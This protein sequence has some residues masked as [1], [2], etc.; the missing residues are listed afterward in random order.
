MK[1]S[2]GRQRIGDCVY[3]ALLRAV[4]VGGT[5]KLAR[6]D[7]KAMCLEAGFADVETYIASGNVVFQA[8]M[9]AVEVKAALA[10]RLREADGKSVGVRDRPA[11]EM[12]ARLETIPFKKDPA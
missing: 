8:K 11:D 5:G 7:L 3:V 9:S 1:G 6:A 2:R 4:N 10:E 12:A